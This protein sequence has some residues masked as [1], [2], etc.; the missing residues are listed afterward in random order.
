MGIIVGG[1][2]TAVLG[3][4]MASLQEG[5]GDQRKMTAQRLIENESITLDGPLDEPVWARAALRT[6]ADR[7]GQLTG[8]AM[9]QQDAYRW[10]HWRYGLPEK[11]TA[12][13]K[14]RST[15]QP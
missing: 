11:A 9:W 13:S 10:I 4:G 3:L 7:T 6:A 15:L 1:L 5:S 14:Q 12:L 8:N 2:C